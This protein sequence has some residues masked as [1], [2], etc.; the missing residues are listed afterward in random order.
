MRFFLVLII[1]LC[2]FFNAN[3]QITGI[4]ASK[5]SSFT[6]RVIP[7]DA[8]EFELNYGVNHSR[9]LWDQD[10]NTQSLY[11]SEDSIN[12]STTYGIRVAYA[13]TEKFELG[14]FVSPSS[15][16]WSTKLNLMDKERFSFAL[17]AGINLPFGN[18]VNDKRNRQASQ[19]RSYGF[20]L[21]S[22]HDLSDDASIDINLQ[23][24]DY[25]ASAPGLTDQDKFFSIDYGQYVHNGT[26]LLIASFAYQ[27]SSAPGGNQ[28]ALSFNPG[29]SFEMNPK[30]PI[31]VNGTF[32]LSGKNMQK[33]NGFNVAWMIAL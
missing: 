10:G 12:V 32:G 14:A 21:I 20:G 17:M 11:R 27:H 19:V 31:A 16:N 28:T 1:I 25:M 24:Q 7:K 22:S 18:V 8:A 15:S 3:S 4:S 6:A 26:I 2:S 30:F 29:I 5:I 13:F 9:K 23:L 33:V